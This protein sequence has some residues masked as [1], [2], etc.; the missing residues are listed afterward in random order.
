MRMSVDVAAP[1]LVL[2]R[3]SQSPERAEIVL[4]SLRYRAKPTVPLEGGLIELST[5]E[6]SGLS[7]AAVAASGAAPLLQRVDGLR[8]VMRRPLRGPLLTSAPAIDMEVDVPPI[9]VAMSTKEYAFIC[10]VLGENF[11]EAPN[12][13]EPVYG[14]EDAAAAGI[15]VTSLAP[16]ADAVV[17]DAAAAAA[18]VA[19]AASAAHAAAAE[20]VVSADGDSTAA[21]ELLRFRLV[22]RLDD[23][24]LL[25]YNGVGRA[26]PL[27]EARL[28]G[29][30]AGVSTSASG[31]TRVAAAVHDLVISDARVT[32]PPDRRAV[33]GVDTTSG[34]ST[35]APAAGTASPMVPTAGSAAPRLVLLIVDYSSSAADGMRVAV[36]LQRPTLAVDVGFLLAVGR[37][38]M[39]SL[40]GGT[41]DAAEAVLPN[42]LVLR[43]GGDAAATTV[44]CDVSLSARRRMLADAPLGG[45]EPHYVFDGGGHALILPPA[46]ETRAGAAPFA[47]VLVG[48]GRTLTLRNARLV[49]AERLE[50]AVQLA[51]GARLVLDPTLKLVYGEEDEGA[52]TSPQRKASSP[53]GVRA[54]LVPAASVNAAAAPA[55]P[56]QTPTKYAM[57]LELDIVG[58][59]LRFVEMLKQ[60]ENDPGAAG[61]VLSAAAVKL[62]GEKAGWLRTRAGA[63]LQ[64]RSDATGAMMGA[65]LH[66]LLVE[67]HL[68]GAG[69]P[70]PLLAPTDAAATYTSALVGDARVGITTSAIDLRLS[71]RLLGLVNRLAASIAAVFSHAPTRTSTSFQLL[72]SAPPPPPPRGTSA[73][74]FLRADASDAV[75]RMCVWRPVAPPGYAPLGDAVTSGT[76]PPAAAALVMRDSG[77]IC[78]PP[79]GY[80][81]RLTVP[82]GISLWEPQPPPGCVAVGCVAAEG[83]E[84]PSVSAVRCP[85]AALVVEALPLE[86]MHCDDNG[87]VWRVGN[88]SGTAVFAIGAG[89]PRPEASVLWDLRDP[90]GV[91]VQDNAAAPP[92]PSPTPAAAPAAATPSTPLRARPRPPCGT[93]TVVEFNRVRAS[94]Q[95]V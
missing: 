1:L 23:V 78:L 63:S 89:T 80:T 46:P 18:Q 72:W 48:A 95:H 71:P 9:S 5:V 61:E 62:R 84:P 59:Q 66:G 75:S 37:F 13:P 64:Y 86:C 34:S 60:G 22:V 19:S 30:W 52:A 3:T 29:G 58:L 85:R 87:A 7:I 76:A 81:K 32:T 10:A 54:A 77:A 73:T 38:F 55:T 93:C 24:S 47:L 2:P 57:S 12:L 68:P 33:L 74:G 40:A 67:A 69:A 49:R 83:D 42:D 25:L 41:A 11:R 91:D 43:A 21:A 8:V 28:V 45:A 31:V 79:L 53:E 36:R 6:S 44:A 16:Q 14:M 90:L 17:A 35:A 70:L 92:P 27:A 51:P 94:Q 4:G 65:Q 50:E 56:G 88:A 15:G 20:K 39:P 82:G 26:H